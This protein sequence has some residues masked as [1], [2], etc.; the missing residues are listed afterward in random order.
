MASKRSRRRE[1]QRQTEKLVKIGQGLL[2]GKVV[3]HAFP[4]GSRR[5]VARVELEDGRR[6]IIVRRSK[7]SVAVKE[8]RIMRGLAANG[9]RVPEVFA[10]NGLVSAQEDLGDR[11]LSQAMNAVPPAEVEALLQ[12]TLTSLAGLHQAGSRA[13]FDTG[14]A[15]LGAG[16]G[17]MRNLFDRP[18]VFSAFFEIE[19]PRLPIDGL[20]L[21]FAVPR[22][23]FI[24]WDARPA[25]AMLADDGAIAWF[26]F[27]DAGARRRL[28]D[29]AWLL[30]DEFTP[31]LPDVEARLIDRHLEGFADG[32]SLPE[33]RRY[34]YAYGAFHSTVRLGL[35]LSHKRD[36]DWWDWDYCLERDKPGVNPIA[37]RR[38]CRRAARWAGQCDETKALEPWFQRLEQ[39][40]EKRLGLP[41][42]SGADPLADTSPPAAPRLE[43]D[44]NRA[45][46]PA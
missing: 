4:G 43:P 23:R 27:E 37:V 44:S 35:I 8:L 13:G 9:A 22:P 46:A 45:V 7:S 17:W 29:V 20:E 25:N 21:L 34:L 10:S 24:K 16:R 39:A 2:G 38:L 5:L 19:P 18:R 32:L 6:A 30:T 31:D 15:P 36:E 1:K 14:L 42:Q 26:D 40:L 12:R 41:D 28:D 11:R 3:S 33:A